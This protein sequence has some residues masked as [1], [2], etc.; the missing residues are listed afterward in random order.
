MVI[1]SPE[2]LSWQL[3]PTNL[4]KVYSVF[5]SAV[6]LAKSRAEAQALHSRNTGQKLQFDHSTA[7]A[8]RAM[9]QGNILGRDIPL[10][11]RKL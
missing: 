7:S 11:T 9:L 4:S 2:P 5:L 6:G 1:L 10:T 3:N 8:S